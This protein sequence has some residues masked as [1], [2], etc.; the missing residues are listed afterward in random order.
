MK[1]LVEQIKGGFVLFCF[2]FHLSAYF[3]GLCAWILLLNNNNSCAEGFEM[4]SQTKHVNF[5]FSSTFSL[6]R[7]QFRLYYGRTK[8]SVCFSG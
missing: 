4:C 3:S 2:V 8:V 6:E 1:T 5:A 7:Q